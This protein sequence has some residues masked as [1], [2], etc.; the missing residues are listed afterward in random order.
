LQYQRVRTAL[1][2]DAKIKIH[3]RRVKGVNMKTVQIGTLV[4][5]IGFCTAAHATPHSLTYSQVS[6]APGTIVNIGGQQFVAVQV[7]MRQ[8]TTDKRYA[9]RFLSSL[10]SDV[11]G[12]FVFAN[13]STQ[14]SDDLLQNS[15]ATIDTF[16][17]R[18]EVSDGRTYSINTVFDTLTFDTTNRLQVE[19]NAITTV[20]VKVGDTLVQ[21]FTVL[22][23]T[24][25]DV[26]LGQN[27]YRGTGLATYG[28]YVDPVGLISQANGLDKWIDYIRIIPLN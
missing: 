21:F 12:D 4:A 10:L 19:G 7:P 16:P 6:V 14:H 20:Q 3:K 11:D 9:V 17:A 23:Q 5:L 28:K 13:L 2:V 8:F 15:N 1:L 24:D 18:I 22:S 26:D 25:Q 27:Q